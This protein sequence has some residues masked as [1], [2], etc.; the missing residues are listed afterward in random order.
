MNWILKR[1]REPSTWRGLTWILTVA[2]ISLHPDQ[3]EA[4]ATVGMAI[5]GLL[6]VFLPEG[7]KADALPKIELQGAAQ[8]FQ[9]YRDPDDD[10]HELRVDVPAR[11]ETQPNGF[12]G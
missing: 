1:A 3:I 4:I 11:S 12:N 8:G 7:T 9:P 6:G 5:A 10:A 2:G